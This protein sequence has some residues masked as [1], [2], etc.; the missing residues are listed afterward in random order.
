M[1]RKRILSGVLIVTVLVTLVLG[2][3]QARGHS[4]AFALEPWRVMG[5]PDAPVFL[6]V[7]SDFACPYCDKIR[8]TLNEMLES[9]PE[10]LK[11][12]FK[13]FPLGIHPPAVPAAEASEC[14]ADQGKFWKYHD[15]LFERRSEW[16]GSKDLRNLLISYGKDMGLEE[17]SFRSCVES[18]AKKQVVEQNRREGRNSFVSGT[19]TLLLNGTKVLVNHKPEY[20][21]SK[22][23]QEMERRH[24]E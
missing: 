3:R 20:I 6:A 1:K 2:V 24:R 17:E 9:Y 19:P 11:I 7:F 21:R 4:K 12:V 14:A 15:L 22:I 10:D 8:S 18:G 16:Y 5:R 13:H 23:Q